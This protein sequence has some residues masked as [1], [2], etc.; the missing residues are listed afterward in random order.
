MEKTFT[1][2][3]LQNYLQE[4]SFLEQRASRKVQSK[5]GPGNLAIQNILRYSGALNILK[6]KSAGTVYQLAN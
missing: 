1:L 5:D 4:I 3:D 2:Q 6:T